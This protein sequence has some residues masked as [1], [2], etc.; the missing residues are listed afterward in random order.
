MV[1]VAAMV[2]GSFVG[3]VIPVAASTAVESGSVTTTALDPVSKTRK[4]CLRP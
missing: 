3:F 1:I 4:H 2:M